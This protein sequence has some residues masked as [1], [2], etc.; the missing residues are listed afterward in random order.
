MYP[1]SV[2]SLS[3]FLLPAAYTSSLMEMFL[4]DK[5]QEAQYRKK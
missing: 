3:F 5:H 1:S 2:V 4:S